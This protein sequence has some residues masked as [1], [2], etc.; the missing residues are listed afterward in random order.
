TFKTNSIKFLKKTQ[1][2]DTVILSCGAGFSLLKPDLLN[3]DKNALIITGDIKWHD[4]ILLNDLNINGLDVGHELEKYFINLIKEF[5]NKKFSELKI[6][7][8]YPTIN[9]VSVTNKW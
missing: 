5:L 3:F 8:H 4:W 9:L 7:K 2:I 1:K 6:I